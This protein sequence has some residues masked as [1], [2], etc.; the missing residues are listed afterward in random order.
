MFQEAEWIKLIFLLADV[1]TWLN[2]LN[3]EAMLQLPIADKKKLAGRTYLLTI[4]ALVHI[5]ERHYCNIN[6]YPQ[7]GKFTIPLTEIIHHI[8]EAANT[9]PVLV[10]GSLNY[11]RVHQVSQAVGFDKYGKPA[12]AISVITDASGRIITAFPGK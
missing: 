5:L 10:P 1:Q 12:T 9:T 11:L 6:R 3:K 4:P 2:D 8:R 7:C